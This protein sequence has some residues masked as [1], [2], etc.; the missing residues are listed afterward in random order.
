MFSCYIII[1]VL[2]IFI[3]KLR[4]ISFF[5]RYTSKGF[6]SLIF[7]IIN[8]TRKML[9]EADSILP[10][11]ILGNLLDVFEVFIIPL[12]ALVQHKARF[13]PRWLSIW[14]NSIRVSYS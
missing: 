8:Q 7:K 10:T 14:G 12:S 4:P 9:Q 2:A 6:F 1:I 13:I 5:K 3:T 11:T